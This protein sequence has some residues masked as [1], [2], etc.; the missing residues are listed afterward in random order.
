MVEKPGLTK[1]WTRVK[2]Y[3][4]KKLAQKKANEIRHRFR[5][6]VVQKGTKGEAW[7]DKKTCYR[8]WVK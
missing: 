1:G 4:S 8:V 7:G 6:C 2:T 5:H 3:S